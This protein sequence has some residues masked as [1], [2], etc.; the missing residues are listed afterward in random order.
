VQ[1]LVADA[2]VQ[3]DAARDILN[4]GPGFFAQIGDLIDE[5]DLRRQKGVG[6]VFGQFRGATPTKCSG[7]WFRL[8]GGKSRSSPRARGSSVPITTGRDA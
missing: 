5:G 3:P 6:R 8:K 2:L 7:G 1:K 4:V